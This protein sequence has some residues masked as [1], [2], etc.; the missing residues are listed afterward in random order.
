MPNAT[1][2]DTMPEECRQCTHWE[3]VGKRI[4]VR[5]LLTSMVD[6]LEARVESEEFKPSVPDFLRVLEVE[7]D[8]RG[9]DEGAGEM[10]VRWGDREET[11]RN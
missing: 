11:A 1:S 2:G 3:Q 7:K 6:K 4:R 8:M 10:T 9:A 5:S